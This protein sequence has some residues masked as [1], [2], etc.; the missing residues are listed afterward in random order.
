MAFFDDLSKKLTEVGQSAAQKTRDMSDMS[1]IKGAISDEEKK[2]NNLIFQIGQTYVSVHY[3]DYGSEFEALMG[4]FIESQAKLEE[5][6]NQLNDIKGIVRCDKCGAEVPSTSGFCSV[7]GN[8][9]VR[10]DVAFRCSGCN[11]PL[12]PGM[13]FCTNCG[14]P[15]TVASNAAPGI[16]PVAQQAE[17]FCT[18]CGAKIVEGV[19]FCTN[20]GMKV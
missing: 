18:N 9:V 6:K 20:C 1:R 3:S 5:Y 7:C 11:A 12:S 10:K 4:A 13:S 16:A 8:Q 2:I 15:V 17:M 19:A 14:T